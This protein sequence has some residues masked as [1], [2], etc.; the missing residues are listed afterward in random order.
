MDLDARLEVVGDAHVAQAVA[1]AEGGDLDWWR[2]VEPPVPVG[3]PRLGG[4]G[5]P[6][7]TE[8]AAELGVGVHGPGLEDGRGR[9]AVG[10]GDLARDRRCPCQRLVHD[11][12]PHAGREIGALVPV[13]RRREAEPAERED[14]VARGPDAHQPCPVG[15]RRGDRRPPFEVAG[16]RVDE[17]PPQVPGR[18]EA[19]LHRAQVGHPLERAAVRL[20]GLRLGG[21]HGRASMPTRPAACRGKPS[22]CW[23]R[24]RPTSRWRAWPRTASRSAMTCTGKA[25]PWCC[26]TAR[27][28]R[29]ARTSPRSCPCCAGA[30]PASCPTRAATRRPGGT[31]RTVSATTGWSTTSRRS[32]TRSASGPSTCSG[33]RWGRRPPC[34]SGRA[35]PSGCCRSWWSGSR[36]A[37]SPGCRSRAG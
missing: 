25:R 22:I 5:P 3:Q 24:C 2:G 11:A 34:S 16:R 32:P 33:S 17:R 20:I 9:G 28:R 29:A 4:R 6:A 8:Q 10:A 23:P 14:L 15:A 13:E 30:S 1:L 7:G 37:A 27:A 31:P 35:G 12:L 18:R 36:P 26:S 21:R 19:G